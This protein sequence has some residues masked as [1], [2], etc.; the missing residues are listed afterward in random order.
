MKAWAVKINGNYDLDL[1]FSDKKKAEK[2]KKFMM[3]EL[4]IRAVVVCV[5]ISE[6]VK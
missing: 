3:G 1:F 5:L 2:C 6:V 4:G